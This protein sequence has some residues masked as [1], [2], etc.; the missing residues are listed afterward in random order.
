MK[1]RLEELEGDTDQL[2]ERARLLDLRMGAYEVGLRD[3]RDPKAKAAEAAA[4]VALPASFSTDAQAALDAVFDSCA[5]EAACVAAHPRLRE[6]WQTLL[7]SLPRM[8]LV[9]D[10]VTGAPETIE[11]T[12][13]VVLGACAVRCMSRRSPPRCPLQS[14]PPRRVASRHWSG[15]SALLSS[16]KGGQRA[17][18]MHFSVV[19][20]EDVR[21]SPRRRSAGRRFRAR[22]RAPVRA[23]LRRLAT[24]RRAGGVLRLTPSRAPVLLL[25]GGL[26]PATPPRHGA[27]SRGARPAGAHVVVPNAGHG[28]MGSAAC[29]MSSSGSS[30]LPTTR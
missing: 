22:L 14:T 9:A 26:D 8:A 15:L 28:V 27:R 2:R 11:I 29:A 1:A 25:S 30:M 6:T 20:A 17:M 10:A 18:G 24:R 16:R 19:C 12:R 4:D 21:A 5:R 23:C 3:L 7:S 13:D